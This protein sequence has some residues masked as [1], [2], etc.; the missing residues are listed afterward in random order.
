MV[1]ILILSSAVK[2]KK[3]AYFYIHSNIMRVLVHAID[4]RNID[5]LQIKY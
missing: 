2:F 5:F 3:I 4:G 1:Q